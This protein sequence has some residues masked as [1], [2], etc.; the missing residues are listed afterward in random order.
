MGEDDGQQCPECASWNVVV[1]EMKK[2]IVCKDCGGIFST[3]AG[4]LTAVDMKIV[5]SK[6]GVKTKAAAKAKP[7]KSAKRKA[8]RAAKPAKKKAK[9]AKSAQ[10]KKPKKGKKK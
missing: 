9:P 2:Q 4:K 1:N 10:G 3:T 7:A 5:S 6:I 8:A